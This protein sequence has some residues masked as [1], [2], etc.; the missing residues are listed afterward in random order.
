M[1][2]PEWVTEIYYG[3]LWYPVKEGTYRETQSEHG[4]TF[5]Y[6]DSFSDELIILVQPVYGWKIKQPEPEEP[7]T[8]VVP[9]KDKK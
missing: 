8:N 9:F 7:K 3:N 2:L 4:D 6:Q 1:F 5:V